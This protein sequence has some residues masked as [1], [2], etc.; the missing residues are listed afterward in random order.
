MR[1]NIS[2]NKFETFKYKTLENLQN[3]LKELNLNLPISRNVNILQQPVKTDKIFIPNRLS[4]Q[5]MEGYDANLDGTPGTLTL[6]RY[7]RYAKGGAGLIWLEAT[8][9]SK[10]CR[11]NP[12]QLMLDG[13]NVKKFRDFILKIRDICNKTLKSMGFQHD[14]VLILQLN[15]SGRYSK[16]DGNKFPIR[17]YQNLELDNA[18]GMSQDIGTIISDA[19]LEKVEEIWTEKALLARD[20]GFDGVDIKSCH[21]Y[22]ISELLTA[23]NRSDSEFGGLSLEKRSKLLLNIIRKLKSITNDN[24]NFLITTRLGIYD[25]TPY[26]NG[27]GIK[28]E[29]NQIF[30][31]PVDLSEPLKLIKLLYN[32]GIK[33]V[34]ISVGNPHYKPHLTRPY[35]T[36]IKGALLPNE[37]PLYSVNRILNLTKLIKQ[38]IPDD[39]VIIGS[40]YSYLRQFAG[41]IAAGMVLN[42]NLD[43]CGFGRMAFANPNFPKQIFHHGSIDKNSVCIACSKCSELM[44]MGKNIGCVIR[45]SKY[46]KT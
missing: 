44:R 45:D 36:P 26:P 34:N 32:L 19:E 2:F 7:K 17:A 1:G 28:N 18:L 23:R 20:V 5:P 41:F 10:E 27:F 12:H 46:R 40:G 16:I 13:S 35:D 30:P 31:A 37:H 8:S 38:Q 24:S 29:E 33:L 25:G 21:G 22:L 9:I 14:C 6:R 39:M 3:K 15:H 11:S 42:N 4:I 43:I